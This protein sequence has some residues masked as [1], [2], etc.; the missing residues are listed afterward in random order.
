MR[1]K[2]RLRQQIPNLNLQNR[3]KG[4]NSN[5]QMERAAKSGSLADWTFQ[6][7]ESEA[8]FPRPVLACSG[9]HRLPA[10]SFRQPAEK[11]SERREP[12]LFG[13]PSCRR[14]AA[15][16]WRLAACAPQ[17]LTIRFE[18]SR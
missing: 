12:I 3:S 5:S 6:F 2:R 1:R 16:D 18:A 8:A 9:E 4:S 17:I 7:A 11:L 13:I 15:D 14:Q 10:C